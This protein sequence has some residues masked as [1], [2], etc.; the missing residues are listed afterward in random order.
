MKEADLPGADARNQKFTANTDVVANRV[1]KGNTVF[2][3]RRN[4]FEPAKM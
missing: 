1:A 2:G 3:L 4:G